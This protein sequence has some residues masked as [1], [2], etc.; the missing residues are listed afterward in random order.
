M[1]K[2]WLEAQPP[3]AERGGCVCAHYELYRWY[4]LQYIMHM[5]VSIV[6]MQLT[7]SAS[8]VILVSLL[9]TLNIFHT[10][11]KCFYC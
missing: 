11:F 9:L 1:L 10:L 3:P 2:I 7:V 6:I 8:G 5:T 4:F